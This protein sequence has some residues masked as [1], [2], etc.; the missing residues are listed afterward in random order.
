VRELENVIEQSLVFAEGKEI[1]LRALPGV[2]RGGADNTL[3]VPSGEMSLPEILE[4]LERQLILRA[5][6]KSGGVKT[7]TARLL[8]IK[9]SALYYKL[10]KYGIGVIESRGDRA[11]AREGAAEPEALLDDGPP[12]PDGDKG[13]R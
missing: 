6:E 2:L 4:D 5:Y 7:E 8:G 9:T 13:G 12:R 11:A 10:E 1:D 3:A